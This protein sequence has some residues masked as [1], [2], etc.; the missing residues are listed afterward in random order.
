VKL[1]NK[2]EKIKLIISDVDGVLTDGT[3]FKGPD[4]LELKRFCVQDGTAVAILKVAKYNLAFISGRFSESTKIRMQELKVSDVYN[5]TLNKLIPYEELKQKFSVED[6][7]IAYIGDD[8][9]DIPVMEKVGLPIAVNNAY[10]DVKKIA[11]FITKT[12]GGEGAFRE[13]VDWMLTELGIY[14]TCLAELKKKMKN[15][16]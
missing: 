5:G 4:N 15:S 14:K 1:K 13:F 8:L 9:I 11:L 12:D 10:P 6:D 7:E 16:S 2:L 3:V